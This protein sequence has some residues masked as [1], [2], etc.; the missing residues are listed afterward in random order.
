MNVSPL[1]K[2]I[3]NE[4]T[5]DIVNLKK[6]EKKI[7]TQTHSKWARR[8]SDNRRRKSKNDSESVLVSVWISRRT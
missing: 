7:E 2:F 3:R 8:T 5:F 4:I 1:I 6:K